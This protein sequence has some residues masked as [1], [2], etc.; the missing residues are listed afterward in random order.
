MNQILQNKISSNRFSRGLKE[1]TLV[2]RI[3][4]RTNDRKDAKFWFA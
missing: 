2:D 3:R 4:S 1:I